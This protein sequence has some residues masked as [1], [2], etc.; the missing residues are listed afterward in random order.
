MEAIKFSA[1]A[2][3][4]RFRS[5]LG[6]AVARSGIDLTHGR[7]PLVEICIGK[8]IVQRLVLSG[9]S[10]CRFSQDG[11]QPA[12]NP[13]V[14]RRTKMCSGACVRGWVSQKAETNRQGV[15]LR[16]AEQLGLQWRRRGE[17]LQLA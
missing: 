6:F 16:E 12:L 2:P 1:P 17:V 14:Q 5:D 3:I 10:Q 15:R 8:R 13:A 4:V 7:Y 11:R 9:I